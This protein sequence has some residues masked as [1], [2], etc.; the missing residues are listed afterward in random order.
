VDGPLTRQINTTPG[1]TRVFPVGHA[2]ATHELILNGIDTGGILKTFLAELIPPTTATTLLPLHRIDQTRAWRL[3]PSSNLPT[4]TRVGL[5]FTADDAVVDPAVA[6]V[7]QA[8][9]ANGPY[10]TLGGTAIG[11]PAS[12]IVTATAD[13]TLGQDLFTVG[14]EAPLIQMIHP[15]GPTSYMIGQP[16]TLHWKTVDNVLVTGVDLFVSHT[17]AGGPFVAIATNVRDSTFGWVV[18][19][20][21]TSNARFRADLH[22]AEAAT[23]SDINDVDVPLINAAVDVEPEMPCEL[24][25]SRPA[26]NP[27]AGAVSVQFVLPRAARARL[28]VLDVQGRDVAVL[29]DEAMS[30]G[31]HALTWE[32]GPRAHAA[33]LYFIRLEAEGRRIVRRLVIAR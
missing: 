26:P 10:H 5:V 25:L 15:N 30:A 7:A 21:A 1:A 31:R 32:S 23:A 4:G 13:A 22:D 28:S 3:S 33:G 27:S 29:A 9:N 2:G 6:R 12:G 18:T 11:T 16:T 20:P 24:Q 8:P 17:G 19:G 14:S